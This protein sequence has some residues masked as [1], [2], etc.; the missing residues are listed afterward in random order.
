MKY[1]YTLAFGKIR[2]S[3]CIY[4]PIKSNCRRK[5]NNSLVYIQAFLLVLELNNSF[6]CFLNPDKM[7]LCNSLH[8]LQCMPFPILVFWDPL[9]RKMLFCDEITIKT[10]TS[11]RICM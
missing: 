7:S 1:I 6:Y 11:L 2:N 5:L 8:R 3:L 4:I 9:T 10:Q